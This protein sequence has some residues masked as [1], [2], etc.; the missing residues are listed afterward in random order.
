MHTRLF[1]FLFVLE[2]SLN[3]CNVCR[4]QSESGGQNGLLLGVTLEIEEK[5]KSVGIA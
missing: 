5:E 4:I 3:K 1:I 2:H